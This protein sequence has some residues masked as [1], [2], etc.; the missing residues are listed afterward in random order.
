MEKNQELRA[1]IEARS[2]KYEYIYVNVWKRLGLRK[3]NQG[4]TKNLNISLSIEKRAVHVGFRPMTY[5]LRGTV[6]APPTEL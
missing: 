1:E 5:S 6:D 4:S 2:E 3:S